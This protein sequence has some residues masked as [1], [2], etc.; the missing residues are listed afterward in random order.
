MGALFTLLNIL[1]S[2]DKLAHQNRVRE[3]TVFYCV[4]VIGGMG[5]LSVLYDVFPTIYI[6]HKV[7]VCIQ[8]PGDLYNTPL[9]SLIYMY[10]VYWKQ[11]ENNPP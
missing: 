3:T 1:D 2:A 11:Q 9:K 7:S 4:W 8:K 10:A 5:Q 6:H